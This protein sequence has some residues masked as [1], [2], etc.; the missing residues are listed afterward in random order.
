MVMKGK[1]YTTLNLHSLCKR[2]TI[3]SHSQNAGT[4]ISENQPF[5]ESDAHER[6]SQRREHRSTVPERSTPDGV[7]DPRH[8]PH[9]RLDRVNRLSS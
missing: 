3:R 2:P 1:E 6:L 7:S 4:G 5:S 9:A 8:S